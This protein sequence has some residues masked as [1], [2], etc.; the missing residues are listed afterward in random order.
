MQLLPRVE[1]RLP[2][3]GLALV[4]AALCSAPVAHGQRMNPK[5]L[6]SAT[7]KTRQLPLYRWFSP[8]RGDNFTT[9]DPRWAGRPGETRSGY[10]FSQIEGYVFSPDLPQ[11][12]GTVALHSWY[13]A[14]D[15]DNALTSD[16]EF[17]VRRAARRKNRGYRQFRLEGYAYAH[18]PTAHVPEAAVPLYTWYSEERGDYFTTTQPDWAGRPGDVR[19]GDYRFVRIEGRVP[20]QPVEVTVSKPGPTDRT[21]FCEELLRCAEDE[22]PAGVPPHCSCRPLALRPPEP[23]G[24]EP[25]RPPLLPSAVTPAIA[26]QILGRKAEEEAYA[27][28]RTGPISSV[29]Y[30]LAGKGRAVDLQYEIIDGLA[31]AEGDI[32][33]GRHDDMTRAASERRSCRGEICAVQSPLILRSGENYLWPAGVVPYEIDSTFTTDERDSINRG[34][35]LVEGPTNL[36][37]KTRENESDYVFFKRVDEGCS[38]RVGRQ[39]GRQTI[40]IKKIDSTWCS[41][42]TVA[43]EILHAV[44]VWHEQ[45][46]EDRNRF[47]R[48]LRQNVRD[49]KGANFDQHISDG[50]DIANYD[51]DSIMHYGPTAFAKTDSSGALLTTIEVLTPGVSIGQRMAL[52]SA[53]IAGVNS[54]YANEDCIY[55]DPDHV[56]IAR[57]SG[58]RWRLDERLG[59]GRTHQIAVAGDNRREAERTLTLVRHYRFDQ[60]CFVGRPDPS[61]VYFLSDGSAATGAYEGEDCVPIDPA[62]SRVVQEGGGWKIVEDSRAGRISV[63]AYPNA[64]E[65]YRTLDIWRQRDF[66][67]ACYVG[68]PDP[69]VSYYR[70]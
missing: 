57:A 2:L 29:A 62:G 49:G 15:E 21:R 44:G 32:I 22:W 26:A 9:S 7:G 48:I 61:T 60:I 63:A 64:G 50:V 34:I 51:Y 38:A 24:P 37:L 6:L 67:F 3:L 30:L 35:G 11:P 40:N 52:S 13:H 27:P 23:G 20:T 14:T 4:L 5:Q 70:R 42:G 58:G 8:S 45:S 66:R 1:T 10:R 55:F 43:H 39:G 69:A 17:R 65:A 47:V 46:R 31:V 12:L 53:D 28:G 18:E 54:L 19:H 36:I 16:P 59:D 33:L 68:R 56:A 41:P 25:G